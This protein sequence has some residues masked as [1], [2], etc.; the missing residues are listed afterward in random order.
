MVLYDQG[1]ATSIL[2]LAWRGRQTDADHDTRSHML[3]R[4]ASLVRLVCYISCGIWLGKVTQTHV[5]ILILANIVA[6]EASRNRAGTTIRLTL[7]ES[8][9]GESR[10]KEVPGWLANFDLCNPIA[11]PQRELASPLQT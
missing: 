7:D 3:N 9:Y 4:H 8:S 1:K 5:L 10:T 11:A 2:L 6:P